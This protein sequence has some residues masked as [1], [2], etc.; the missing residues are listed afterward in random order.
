MS[1]WFMRPCSPGL[2]PIDMRCWK[3]NPV[4]RSLEARTVPAPRHA[5]VDAAKRVT[6]DDVA[7]WTCARFGQTTGA[8][9]HGGRCLV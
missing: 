5:I 2:D 3:V 1:L 7:G 9:C 4:L 8:R 6:A